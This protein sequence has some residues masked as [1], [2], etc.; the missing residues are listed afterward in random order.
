MTRKT[1]GLA[2]RLLAVLAAIYTFFSLR[3][4]LAEQQKPRDDGTIRVQVVHP[5]CGWLSVQKSA[6]S[7]KQRAEEPDEMIRKAIA[8]PGTRIEMRNKLDCERISRMNGSTVTTP[9]GSYRI[10]FESDLAP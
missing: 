9:S 10:Q 4:Q 3:S 2:V 6:E 5:T 7:P 8:N 1:L